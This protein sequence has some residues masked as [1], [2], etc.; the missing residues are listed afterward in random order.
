V[1]LGFSNEGSS[2]TRSRCVRYLSVSFNEVNYKEIIKGAVA[3]LYSPEVF[4]ILVSRNV[5]IF[6]CLVP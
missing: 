3:G 1:S 2:I 5:R 6:S 4:P